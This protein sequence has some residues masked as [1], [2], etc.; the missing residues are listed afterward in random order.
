[1]KQ[2]YRNKRQ[3]TAFLL[4][5]VMISLMLPFPS[6][7]A[8]DALG[9]EE[10][11][12]NFTPEEA[13]LTA[14]EEPE[15]EYDPLTQAQ[16]E[17]LEHIQLIR[18]ETG[19]IGFDGA[20][21]PDTLVE[22]IVVF[23]VDPA[24]V[25]ALE[26]RARGRAFSSNV[27]EQLV[28]ATHQVFRYELNALLGAGSANAPDAL[29]AD[30]SEAVIF[31]QW[32]TV[33][34]G[35]AIRV[36]FGMLEDVADISVVRAVYENDVMYL[37]PPNF[38]GIE[39]GI[40]EILARNPL[41][42][43]PGRARMQADIMHGAGYRGAGVVVAVIDTGLDWNHPAFD[44][45]FLTYAEQAARFRQGGSLSFSVS[46]TLNVR[47]EQ[48]FVG[49]NLTG[50]FGVPA[51]EFQGTNDPNEAR[52]GAWFNL[53][54]TGARHNHGTHVAGTI[55]ARDTGGPI[56]ALGVAPEAKIFAY[57]T[58]NPG[59]TA[60]VA[61]QAYEFLTYDLPD[62]VNMSFGSA[63]NGPISPQT[64][65]LVNL[66]LQFPHILLINSAGNSGPSAHTAGAPGTAANIMSVGA[67]RDQ[68]T[69]RAEI[70]AG[71][72]SINSYVLGLHT[73]TQWV[74]H[75]SG[76]VPEL[77][78]VLYSVPV[79][80]NNG[81]IRIFALPHAHGHVPGED[82][83]EM[84]GR[85]EPEDFQRLFEIADPELL[86]GSFVLAR[87][88]I[89]PPP[90][91]VRA[92]IVMQNAFRAGIS[93][94]IL[95]APDGGTAVLDYAGT[96]IT[97][98]QTFSIEF[99]DGMSI[100]NRMNAGG[101]TTITFGERTEFR[102]ISLTNWSSRGPTN[103]FDINP[104]IVGDG[105]FVFSP[106][107]PFSVEWLD[108]LDKDI[109]DIYAISYMRMSGTSM[110]AP[111]VA[112][113][114]AL[115][116]EYGRR[117]HE[118]LGLGPNGWTSSEIYTRIMNTAKN[119]GSQYSVMD[120]GSGYIQVWDAVRAQTTVAVTYD[121]LATT[122]DGATTATVELG[123]ISFGGA[124][125]MFED[126][127]IYKEATITNHSNTAVTYTLSES[128]TSSTETRH[129]QVEDREGHAEISFPRSVTVPAG[130]SVTISIGMTLQAGSPHGWYEGI[131]TVDGGYGNVV[132][133]PFAKVSTPTLIT[134]AFLYRDVISTHP[135]AT[136]SAGHM[137]M[138][139][140]PH[141][142]HTFDAW[143]FRNEAATANLDHT[144][145]RNWQFRDSLVGFG[146]PTRGTIT[147]MSL[148][149]PGLPNRTV[150]HDG[151]FSWTD[152]MR[153]TAAGGEGNEGFEVPSTAIPRQPLPEGE[154]ILVVET[155]RQVGTQFIFPVF[156]NLD[157][158]HA[159]IFPFT[160][161]NTPPEIEISE[162]TIDAQSV[163][164]SGNIT[165]EFVAAAAADGRTFD[166][167]REGAPHGP[168][169]S[170]SN[171]IKAWILV[172][173]LHLEAGP[174][175]NL[176]V[177]LELDNEGNFSHTLQSPPG[178]FTVTVWAVDN[179]TAFPRVH[180]I[181]LSGQP[182]YA[183]QEYFTHPGGLPIIAD[184][185]INQ[186]LHSPG[187][188]IAG[189]A[190]DTPANIEGFAQH[191]WAGLNFAEFMSGFG[192]ATIA[193]ELGAADAVPSTIAP[194]QITPGHFMLEQENFP[195]D[196]TRPLHRF[197]GW[198]LQDA[199][200][201]V[202]VDAQTRMVSRNITLTA[203]WIPYVEISFELNDSVADPA[204]PAAIAPIRIL[205]D[206]EF[207]DGTLYTGSNPFPAAP[208]RIDS[209]F[210]GWLLDGTLI[211]ENTLVPS[212]S[213]AIT[214]VANWSQYVRLSFNLNAANTVPDEIDT[215]RIL[216]DT[217]VRDHPSFPEDPARAGPW[218]FG[219]WEVDANVALAGMIPGGAPALPG[220]MTLWDAL[221]AAG[222]VRPGEPIPPIITVPGSLVPGG[223]SV[224]RPSWFPPVWPAEPLF[225]I[226]P[227]FMMPDTDLTLV[228]RWLGEF[229]IHFM[230][231]GTGADSI[232]SLRAT[233]R[234]F[235]MDHEDFPAAPAVTDGSGR[236]FAGWFLNSARTTRL[237][238]GHIIS[239]D[240]F[241]WPQF[242]EPID[243]VALVSD[244]PGLRAAVAQ[245]N[246]IHTIR[247]LNNI[248]LTG[249]T[250]NIP[251][252]RVLTIESQP[253][254]P[255]VTLI[256]DIAATGTLI[257]SNGSVISN[258]L[259]GN[260]TIR[261]ITITRSFT[262]GSIDDLL[263]PGFTP[264]PGLANL[265]LE[266]PIADTS[267]RGILNLGR[268]YLEDVAITGHNRVGFTS[269]L[270]S[271]IPSGGA[272]QNGANNAN[273]RHAVLT[274]RN[275][276]LDFNAAVVNGGAILNQNG[277]VYMDNTIVTSNFSVMAGGGMGQMTNGTFG[278]A[279][280]EIT[281]SQF[282]YNFS[283]GQAGAIGLGA[284]GTAPMFG[285][286]NITDTEI[287]NNTAMTNG[288]AIIITAPYQ[289][290]NIYGGRIANNAGGQAF[291]ED[292]EIGAANAEGGGAIRVGPAGTNNVNP[293]TIHINGT[294]IEG[295]TAP[296][297]GAINTNGFARVFLRDATVRNNTAI[298]RGGAVFIQAAPAG[299]SIG[300]IFVGGDDTAIYGNTAQYG[301]GGALHIRGILL[302]PGHPDAAEATI[303]PNA[304]VGNYPNNIV[305]S[306]ANH[307]L[308]GDFAGIGFVM[309]GT[310]THPASPM[311]AGSVI[312]PI[313]DYVLNHV[314]VPAQN[315]AR[316]GHEFQGWYTLPH[317]A[318]DTEMIRVEPGTLVMEDMTLH[319]GWRNVTPVELI[320]NL[321]GT[322]EAPTVPE[323]INPITLVVGEVI[324]SNENFP[325]DPT[326][327]GYEFAGWFLNQGFTIEILPTTI[328]PN[329][330]Q[331]AFA[332]WIQDEV[333]PVTVTFRGNDGY[334]VPADSGGP[335]EPELPDV[336]TEA[337]EPELPDVEAE[338][339]E[340]ELPETVDEDALFE[341]FVTQ[342]LAYAFEDEETAAEATEAA[343]EESDMQEIPEYLPADA[344]E[345][346]YVPENP[347]QNEPSVIIPRAATAVPSYTITLSA[348]TSIG[349]ANM[350]TAIRDGR[351]F[352]GWNTHADGSGD[353]FSGETVVLESIEVFAIWSA[354]EEPDPELEAAR[355]A[356]RELIAQA[357]AREEADYTAET[358]A[359][360]QEA[361]SA[362]R[363]ALGSEDISV[364]RDATA[365]LSTAL[366]A[367][368]PVPPDEPD[369]E[370]E[371]AREALRELIAQA[372][373]RE[374]AD[375]TAETWAVLQEALSAARAALDSE[376]I[377][378]I[379]D[380]TA[381]LSTALDA[382]VPAPPYEPVDPD[383]ELEAARE[384]L[385]ELIAQAEAREEDD[386]TAETWT[387]LQEAL[388]AARAALDS[389][390][391]SVIR[392]A[393]A[394]LS[395][396]L[397]SLVPAPPEDGGVAQ[398]PGAPTQPPPTQPAPPLQQPPAATPPV[399]VDVDEED[400]PLAPMIPLPFEDVSSTAWF[401]Q[402]VRFAFENGLMNGISETSFAPNM[403]LSRAMVVTV[404]YRQ[405]D[406]P[407]VTGLQ[408]PFSDVAA[409][410]WYTDAII[411]GASN[412]IIL[413]F[414]DGRFEPSENV[415]RQ[416]LAL[417]LV[418][419][420][421]MFELELP[422]LNSYQ[423][424]ID[425]YTVAAY[426]RDAVVR[427]VE[428]GLITGRPG[429]E[430]DPAGTATRAEAVAMIKRLLTVEIEETPEY[431]IVLEEQ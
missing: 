237:T 332:R 163:V 165:D 253:G 138:Q 68:W 203:V 199:W 342:T 343:S 83:R 219:G 166:I 218:T 130:G 241:L 45:A 223:I 81:Q 359:T 132:T 200:A 266:I 413:G 224:P 412:G 152:S 69:E 414:G 303:R 104:D 220:N 216:S 401:Y 326:R 258:P 344:Y 354:I 263:P 17:A 53:N 338:A 287:S 23:D 225:P 148:G 5:L 431:A 396:A 105:A 228:A 179:H 86:R 22:A 416:D 159:L 336:G 302:W 383:P 127:T 221:I 4:A 292:L 145:W 91:G 176:P 14:G 378:V 268:L 26:A 272:I 85:G 39:A 269:I 96:D 100:F 1:M 72:S 43:A 93:G 233:E 291:V 178:A 157:V 367:L 56:S 340:P 15:E 376:Y 398:P 88:A 333:P 195:S 357:E 248:R 95:V 365:A 307:I 300:A 115:M 262:L 134:E 297:G 232:P 131:L 169:V 331:T 355:E 190:R 193:F 19:V 55:A 125:V 363:A 120:Q 319:A 247:M 185:A 10:I 204:V 261:G 360:L 366:D 44:G 109:E 281:N 84:L 299:Q 298:D 38:E 103:T 255:N 75:A 139:Y 388:S 277:R 282:T 78:D 183:Q 208:V 276:R 36:P 311:A 63:D 394:A 254:V 368:A 65:A 97:F 142:G 410:R 73:T 370:L 191:V 404:L 18:N 349:A 67:A 46:D 350:P 252:N 188:P 229:E 16:L 74:R 420:A 325:A 41:G 421:D 296:N 92:G 48:L 271:L 280:T 417:I 337:A 11:V 251:A 47:G 37:D 301:D 249:T 402:Y 316:L 260:L 387:D 361:L 101:Y 259:T 117:N 395:N 323:S 106:I 408:N 427:S 8:L 77:N 30:T 51:G 422:E 397:D 369:P 168:E 147:E 161:D 345:Q 196:P 76:Y 372:E 6:A 243:G 348:G 415:R 146:L 264:P 182:I 31:A 64:L 116:V 140:T 275:S 240:T 114:V 35:V 286:I 335:A 392:D 7:E 257:V 309:G 429:G 153:G 389:E 308:R 98:A 143:I 310:L 172:G 107:P 133:L 24:G 242:I 87:S 393:A 123:S 149:V 99:E 374:E 351:Q 373:A 314:P 329:S 198:R 379:R 390:Y 201:D 250:L 29:A 62:V 207:M 347:A 32:R 320:F 399:V 227:D 137:H 40:E 377:S 375:Y 9:T 158:D 358:W 128:W 239:G 171:N 246:D 70:I 155:H 141:F 327:E 197:G 177:P 209:H 175:Q 346:E 284:I 135:D 362:A 411:W 321:G 174:L 122:S 330:N 244:Q 50:Q 407:S 214:L 27:A 385:R 403:E 418:R 3:I 380:A 60:S 256:G 187:I 80:H 167:W 170:L 79:A 322:E 154:Y 430:L 42:N 211:N 124:F 283:A 90:A 334:V 49:R 318:Q 270:S 315:P 202:V 386:Y 186:Y 409:G 20:I 28:E 113:G 356:L 424:F 160:V 235:V 111:H 66:G 156:A 238:S 210:N 371:A 108:T 285:I 181:G 274:I 279:F 230:M 234:T 52:T 294:I 231:A 313:G 428:A 226:P 180:Q 129:P 184:R 151:L 59:M 21:A 217:V 353:T 119:M 126:S 118:R 341:Q 245:S 164:I 267:G 364:I 400:T 189:F 305:T 25:Q 206:T 288:G 425:S 419:F 382:L 102:N 213:T 57:R 352:L 265:P 54:G 13:G 192:Q 317:G 295:N 112:G 391:I 278:P 33:L 150:I 110:S 58:F 215:L 71:D 222:V 406:S 273:G 194:I 136:L 339:T 236:V 306:G 304:V 426:A 328:M 289:I 94:I 312:S 205:A 423:G 121:R 34:N 144:N 162:L 12:A 324:R 212:D 173:E 405:A 293:P 61:I 82:G 290:M 384:A 89:S 2:L 381:A